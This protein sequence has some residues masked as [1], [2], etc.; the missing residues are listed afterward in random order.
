M[1]EPFMVSGT[2]RNPDGQEFVI[3]AAF[4]VEPVPVPVPAPIITSLTPSVVSFAGGTEVTGEGQYLQQG[5]VVLLGDRAASNVVVSE[6][7]TKVT[8]TS[9][10]FE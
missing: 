1:A 5:M 3:T 9:P 2:F 10:S 4:T 7:G 8:F 6:D